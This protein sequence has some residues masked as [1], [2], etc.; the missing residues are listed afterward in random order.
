MVSV[1][2]AKALIRQHCSALEPVSM[3][4]L[5][6]AG[7]VL[8][9][10][11]Y[12]PI[13]IPSYPQ[14][15]MDGY[16]IAFDTCKPG[17][18]LEVV[19]EVAAGDQL[20]KLVPPGK[21]VRIFT[22]APV[23]AGAD[24]IVMQEKITRE[25]KNIQIDFSNLKKGD[26]LRLPGSEIAKG[27]LALP[28]GSMLKPGAIGF[29]AG[30]G[31]CTAEVYPSPRIALIITG[32]ELQVA[33]Q[34]LEHGQVYESNGITLQTALRSIGHEVQQVYYV[35]DQLEKMKETLA[36]ALDQHDL[37][38]ITGGVSVGD[39]DFTIPAAHA[40][41]VET[42]FHKVKQKPGKPFFFGKKANKIVF[43]LPG[44]PSSVLT[45][46]YEYVTEA[47]SLLEN[48][49]R[50]LPVR[51]VMSLDNFSKSAPLQFFLKGLFDGNAFRLLPAQESYKMNSFALANCLAV[52]P[53]DSEGFNKG[54]EIEIHLLP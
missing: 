52:I 45:C 36:I 47:L 5:Q 43:G 31:I 37:I 16:A 30:M 7:R 42:I 26:H 6:A 21:A 19:D 4:L 15:G 54:D 50:R 2:Q 28:A 38:L 25:G 41:G 34:P 33:G 10:D 20:N 3:P 49:D 40:C 48:Q 22:G 12:S 18:P 11:M 24:T 35:G 14:S 8:A 46:Y 27:V 17:H 1:E 44:N 53:E 23:P 13:D 29:L 39:Y 51:K 32:N 9:K